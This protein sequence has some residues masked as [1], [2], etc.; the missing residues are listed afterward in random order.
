MIF[1]NS[2]IVK[3]IY[4]FKFYIDV[5]RGR[6]GWFITLM[7]DTVILVLFLKFV[8]NYNVTKDEAVKFLPVFLFLL[9]C[10]GYAWYTSGLYKIEITTNANKDPVYSKLLDAANIVIDKEKEKKNK[11]EKSVN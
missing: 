4:T 3:W 11:E 2:I 1:G 7:Q 6:L 8:L 5:A 9:F 10:F